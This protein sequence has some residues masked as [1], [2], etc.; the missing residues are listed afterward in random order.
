[1]PTDSAVIQTEALKLLNAQKIHIPSRIITFSATDRTAE[2]YVDGT[3]LMSRIS[4]W[5]GQMLDLRDCQLRGPHNAEN[6]LAALAVGHLVGLSLEKT[7]EALKTYQPAAHRCELVAEI[8]GVKFVNDSKAT[9]VD[10]VHKALLTVGDA[11]R[12]N[13]WLIAGGK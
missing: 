7:V 6:L 2:L 13:V 10:A 1:T 8:E 3:R 4:E 12:A 9:N 5:P 11:E